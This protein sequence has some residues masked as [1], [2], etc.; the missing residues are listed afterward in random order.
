MTSHLARCFILPLNSTAE[1]INR[2]ANRVWRKIRNGIYLADKKYQMFNHTVYD[3]I[4]LYDQIN[5]ELMEKMEIRCFCQFQLQNL[6]PSL[7]TNA[8]KC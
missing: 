5:F 7:N 8:Q 2:V 4:V 3:K 1:C 6:M